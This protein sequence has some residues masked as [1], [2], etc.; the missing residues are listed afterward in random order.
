MRSVASSY[1][2]VMRFPNDAGVIEEVFGDQIMSKQCFVTVN[3][4]RAAKGYVHSVEEPE[5]N[6][7]FADV[8][9]AADQKAVEDLVEV[10]IDEKN[11]DKFFLLGSSLSSTERLEVLEFLTS[12]IEVFAWTPYDMP[13]IDPNFIC[14]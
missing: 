5:S 11:P 10:R 2:Q 4:S 3:G 12:N 9:K 7:L 6:E 1:H 8:G 13:G 14:H